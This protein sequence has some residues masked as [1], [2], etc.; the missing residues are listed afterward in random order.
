MTRLLFATGNKAKLAQLAFVASIVA[1]EV[2]VLSARTLYGDLA[3]Y[4][5]QGQTVSEIARRGA[6][7]VAARVSEAV[8]AEDT[9]FFVDALAGQPGI[10][11]GRYLISEG[12]AGL[13]QRLQGASSRRA[14]VS[15]A[16][17]YATPSGHGFEW[18]NEIHG[19][20]SEEERFSSDYP[21]W[22]APSEPGG[23]GGGY[24]AIFVPDGQERTLAEIAP[25]EALGWSYRERNFE[26]AL[27]LLAPLLRPVGI[28]DELRS[29]LPKLAGFTAF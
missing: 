19:T 18:L 8:L 9:G 3:R 11:A 15:S 4:E 23:P 17:C 20:V 2:E 12:R 26:Q 14:T 21:S 24:N 10:E 22:V 5:E 16:L 25:S 6:L 28:R 27:N 13:L 29:E 7:E 1:P